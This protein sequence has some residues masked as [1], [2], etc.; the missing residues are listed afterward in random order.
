MDIITVY[1][2]SDGVQSGG[3]PTYSGLIGS[4]NS[5]RPK[6]RTTGKEAT[7][8]TTTARHNDT[9][10][11]R[12]AGAAVSANTYPQGR[13]AGAAHAWQESLHSRAARRAER[14]AADQNE[15]RSEGGSTG[16]I[17]TEAARARRQ[18][19]RQILACAESLPNCAYAWA[20]QSLVSKQHRE[21]VR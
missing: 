10:I 8:R 7:M 18:T 9:A 1:T 12:R 11:A 20:E 15:L 14:R 16:Q 13:A 2:K 3:A 4:T 17:A 6:G 21:S 19:E 5:R